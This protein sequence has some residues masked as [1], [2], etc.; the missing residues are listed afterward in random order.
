MTTVQERLEL[1]F[2]GEPVDEVQI[3]IVNTGDGLSEALKVNPKMLHLG[4]Q[5]AFVLRGEVSQVNHRTKKK[6]DE[7]DARVRVHTVTA[8]GVTEVDLEVAKQMLQE[9]ALRLAEARAEQDGQLLL[10][11]EEE[12]LEREALD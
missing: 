9:A 11:R 10:G 12:A 6:K 3:R 5:V 2:E 4:D 8:I 1:E 7:D